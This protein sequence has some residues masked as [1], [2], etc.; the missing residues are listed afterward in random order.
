MA[1]VA[2]FQTY[3]QVEQINSC[4][5]LPLYHVGGLMQFLR[6]LVSGGRLAVLP[7]KQL[8]PQRLDPA[9]FF[10]SL[11]PTQLQ[12]LMPD[13]A[14]WL[15][16]FRTVFLGGAPAWDALLCQARQQQIP[17]APTYGM[18]ETAAQIATL[19][20]AEFLQGKSGCGQVLPHAILTIVPDS[21][22]PQVSSASSPFGRIAIQ[23]KSLMLGYFPDA[24]PHFD[25]L[26]TDDLGYFDAQG[27]LQ[28]VGRSSRKIITGG[29]NVFPTEV[30]AAIRATGL[31]ADVYVVGMPDQ[32]WGEAIV[33]FCVA[34]PKSLETLS[35]TAS[36]TRLENQLENRISA[37]KIAIAPRLS[38]YKQPKQWILVDQIPRNEQGKV[39]HT[40]LKQFLSSGHT[41]THLLPQQLEWSAGDGLETQRNLQ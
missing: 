29:E 26:L 11:V 24:A 9:D 21:V 38:R 28:I 5:V 6:S 8:T 20:P 32:I 14:A 12:R 17:L 39:S 36:E 41:H 40:Q 22:L 2:G 27:N 30:E 1:T 37:L 4:S 19:K 35:G 13:H 10:L 31:V 25:K 33:A 15:R 18:T 34:L 3:F 23:A 7:F 16:Q